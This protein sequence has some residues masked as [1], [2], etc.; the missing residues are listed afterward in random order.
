[1]FATIFAILA[2]STISIYAQSTPTVVCIPGQCLQG[3]SNT[4]IGARLSAPGAATDIHLLPGQYTATT[5]PQILHNLL[6]ST[7]ATLAAS[8]GFNSSLSLPLNL[9]L[10]PGLAVYSGSLYSGQAAFSSLPSAPVG[11]SSVP[12]TSQS[13]ALSSGVWASV[14]AGSSNRVI[15]WDSIPDLNQLPSGTLGSLSLTNIESASCS[16]TC[17]GS[18]IC[19]SSG[20]CQCS[21]GFTGSS[22]ESCA[23]G[24]FG[25]KCQ[26]CPS[27]CSSCDDGISGSGRCLQPTVANAPSTCNCLNGV[28]G[29]NGQCT[30]NAGFTT[31]ANGT[32]CAKCSPGFFL[33]STGDCQV[34]Q[35]G[36]TQCADGTGACT[37]CKTG[38]SQD[39]SDK[40]KCNPPQSITSA[41]TICPDGSF[42]NGNACSACSS[43][44]Q[45]CTAG[46]SNDCILCSAGHYTFQGGCVA[47]NTNGVCAGTNLIA[48]NNKRECD[49]CGAKCTSCII[50]NF[51]VASTV[52]QKQC[53]GCIPGFFLSNGTC[54]S[55]CPSGTFVSPQDNLTCLACDS[56]CSTCAGSSTFCL[57]CSSNQLASGGKCVAT[58]PSNTFSASGSCLTCHPDCATCSGASFNQC[59]SC[60]SSRPV[61]INGR[62]LPTCSKSQFFD[63]TTSSCQACDSSCSSCSGAGPSNCLAC[64]SPTQVLRKGTCVASN[65]QSGTSVIAG[66]GVCLSDLVNVPQVSGTSTLAPLPT[67]TG[68]STPTAISKRRPLEWWEILLMALGCA[69]IFLVVIWCCRRR[70]RKQRAKKTALFATGAVVNRGKTSWRWRLI[71]FGEKL[72]GH[73]RSTRVVPVLPVHGSHSE[74]MKLTKIHTSDI[75]G[76]SPLHGSTGDEEDMVRL[77]GSYQR[78]VSPEPSRFH[79]H[80]HRLTP[81]DQ[82][83]IS[84]TSHVSAPSIYSQMT[85]VPRRVPDPRQPV[86]KELT[87]RF[88]S[89]TLSSGEYLL[90][91]TN[92]KSSKNPFWK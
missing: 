34:C 81:V 92:P 90:P 45:T 57:T 12:L 68:L 50:A 14:N 42:A 5:S 37:T 80:H 49:S 44:C 91:P 72:F 25:P 31:A 21:A 56:T 38:F 48:D 23:S 66:L 2:F 1:M 63:P 39:A 83:S 19:T 79:T 3:Y 75:S 24:F 52:N 85:G 73:H 77:I 58:C 53:T 46:T 10:Q 18:G 36:C 27:G 64:S 16:P 29:S 47:A 33:T 8:S 67:I 11:N 6:A 28:C 78:P 41:G 22:C 69:F 55:A 15:L 71:R 17:A 4:T 40:T 9:A 86:K 65:C 84:E 26:A 82:R 54:V 30:C 87:S 76:P 70:R 51:S 74:S 7:S 35:L 60:P 43:S 20:T 59:T 32:A 13:I 89:S 88:S 61:L 62:C